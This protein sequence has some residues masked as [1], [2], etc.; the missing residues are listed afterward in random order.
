MALVEGCRHELEIT[1]PVDEVD[2]ETE[3]AVADIQKKV[4]LPGF[5]PGKA[6]ASLVRTKFSQEIRQEVVDALL[7]KAF[8]EKA[9]QENLSVVGQPNVTDLHFHSGEPLK[10]KISFEVV[11]SVELGEYR[12]VTVTY[13]EPQVS[14]ADIT[15][16][17]DYVRDQKAEYVNLDPRPVEDG[18]FAVISLK[19]TGGVAEPVEQDEL[20]LHVGDPDTLPEF[21]ENLR[22]MNPGE[23]KD[24]SITYPEDYGQGKLAGKTVSF[25]MTLKAIRRKE[26]PEANDEF[27]RDLGDFQ[28]LDEFKETLR[29]Q[30]FREREQKAQSEAKQKIV[31]KIV[32]S[33][34]FPVPE[35]FVDR[36]IESD[37]EQQLRP[38]LAQGL[39]PSKLN[40]DWNKVRE[41]NKEKAT[42]AVKASML[43][44]RIAERESIDVTN[45][46]V[47]REVQRLAR[48]QRE[49]VAAF[50]MKL[51]K[52]GTLRRIA[53]AIRN[54]KT[55]NWLFE[56]AR[57]E[58]AAE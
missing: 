31:E 24:F 35:V 57:K 1:V 51:E 36:Q 11:P 32:D 34:E 58:A 25:H 40:L 46:D 42:R 50:R 52:D 23:E 14:E 16:R 4:K 12:G 47:D 49:P 37:L 27:A 7:P 17:L 48:Q 53:Q 26:M 29:Q 15:E 41:A 39:D 43:I 55:L 8:R 10:F 5:R 22:G 3:R 45:D 2:R 44:D 19:S 13:A 56:N 20:M 28:S 38:L 6:P 18:D 9:E 30:I 21:T 33:H 54:E